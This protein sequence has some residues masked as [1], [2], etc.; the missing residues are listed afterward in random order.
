MSCTSPNGNEERK[1]GDNESRRRSSGDGDK[2][3]VSPSFRECGHF[4]ASYSV[5]CP[6]TRGTGLLPKLK[7]PVCGNDP[8]VPDH[9]KSGSSGIPEGVPFYGGMNG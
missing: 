6:L 9:R 7:A 8:S 1:K 2:M 4:M 3:K 5:I